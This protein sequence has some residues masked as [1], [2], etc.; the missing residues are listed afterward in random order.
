[1]FYQHEVYLQITRYEMTQSSCKCD[2]KSNPGMK[3][4]LVRVFSCKRPLD[5]P[6]WV[7]SCCCECVG[8]ANDVLQRNEKTLIK[9]YPHHKTKAINSLQHQETFKNSTPPSKFNNFFSMNNKLQNYMQR[10]LNLFVYCYTEPIPGSFPFTFKVQRFKT[11]W[12]LR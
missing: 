7:G 8:S 5:T 3:L 6:Y 12:M 10:V 4:A 11:L 9:Q 2:T 1:M